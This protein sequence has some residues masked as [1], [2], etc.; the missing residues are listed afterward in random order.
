VHAPATEPIGTGRTTPRIVQIVPASGWILEL[1]ETDPETGYRGTVK[2]RVMAFALCEDERGATSV[3]PVT[4]TGQL[5]DPAYL[6]HEADAAVMSKYQKK[7]RSAAIATDGAEVAGA[8]HAPAS[9]MYWQLPPDVLAAGNGPGSA[10]VTAMYED[11]HDAAHGPGDDDAV[12]PVSLASARRMSA[13]LLAWL[14]ELLARHPNGVV[15]EIRAQLR[16]L[17]GVLEQGRRP[18]ATE[19]G[20]MR[21]D[22]P[23]L[24]AIDRS[25]AA[26]LCDLLKEC[27]EL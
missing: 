8:G 13:A 6:L 18:T 24:V 12:D 7:K 26:A 21:F 2:V 20:A 27:E 22:D 4:R 23:A 3:L 9:P 1:P 11:D 19:L 15:R 10:V 14:A 25:L 17:D 16:W 5:S